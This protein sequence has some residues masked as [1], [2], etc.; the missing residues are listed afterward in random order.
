MVK[1]TSRQIGD[2]K[3]PHFTTSISPGS[4]EKQ[5]SLEC[6]QRGRKKGI[7]SWDCGDWKVENLQGREAVMT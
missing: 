4:P 6:V 5:T 1:L 3:I 2:L 7:G